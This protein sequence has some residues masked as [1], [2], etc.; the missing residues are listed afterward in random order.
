MNKKDNKPS[1]VIIKIKNFITDKGR[2]SFFVLLLAIA[3]F[4]FFVYKVKTVKENERLLKI[5]FISDWEYGHQEKNS[6]NHLADEYLKNVV[7]HL[8]SE[9]KPNIAV[10]GGDYIRSSRISSEE[11][12]EQLKY[13]NRIFKKIRSKRLYCIGN[14]DLKKLAKKDVRNILGLDYNYTSVDIKGIRLIVMDNNY[15]LQSGKE[16]GGGRVSQEELKWLDKQINTKL[17]VLIFTHYSP[18][19]I[20]TEHG[21]EDDFHS[22]EKLTQLLEKRN[23]VV[24]VISGDSSENHIEKNKG[25]PYISVAGLIEDGYLGNFAKIKVRVKNDDLK[26]EVICKDGEAGH[27]EITRKMSDRYSVKITK[28]IFGQKNSNIEKKVLWSNVEDEDNK[29]GRISADSGTETNLAVANTGNIYVAFQDGHYEDKAHVKMYN[30]EKWRDLAD[31]NNNNGIISAEKGGDPYIEVNG[32]DIYVAFMDF[33]NDIRARVKKWDGNKWTDVSDKRSLNG[34]ISDMKGHEPVLA[35]DRSKKFLYA[36]FGIGDQNDIECRESCRVK[37]KKWD[38]E[39]WTDVSDKR[40]ADG[41]I[42]ESNG[43]EVD[44]IAS[45]KDD[46]IF[47]AFED[48]D[49]GNRIRVKK[50]DGGKWTDVSDNFHRDNTAT[51]IP[52]S[53]PSLGIDEDDNLF[54]VYTGLNNDKTH[55]TKWNGSN[56]ERVGNGIVSSGR[57][58]ES[59]IT[60][61]GSNIFVAYSYFKK[62]VK[63]LKSKKSKNKVKEYFAESN[64]WRVRVEKWN[65]EKWVALSDDNNSDGFIS[66]GNGKGDPSMAIYQNELFISWTDKKTGY[67]ARVKKYEIQE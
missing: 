64:K 29:E 37:V 30:G 24:A 25:I 34:F 12:R 39:K 49:N 59:C 1:A 47:F 13:M 36:A 17:P 63:V 3:A 42:S 4:S 62:S 67:S 31:D 22:A 46:S 55:I 43:T 44:I 2:V 16:Y 50:W 28:N 23:N 52:G 54:L 38:G 41:I 10:G 45:K 19:R 14:H 7:A 66:D 15:K 33:A 40:F 57:N 35:F 20:P 48:I 18:I 8:N 60:V 6:S 65:G 58:V 56:W 21:W 11:A 32:D 27:F 26:L 9:F 61:D 51:D 5:G 53:S